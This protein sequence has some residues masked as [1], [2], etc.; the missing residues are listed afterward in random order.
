MCELKWTHLSREDCLALLEQ[1]NEADIVN[2]DYYVKEDDEL[3]RN[4]NKCSV[5]LINFNLGVIK[6]DRNDDNRKNILVNI[7]CRWMYD[8]NLYNNRLL[9]A[10]YSTY[11]TD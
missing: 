2:C 7:S 11:S 9:Y 1:P 10:N 4:M 3:V 5:S 8:S 6:L